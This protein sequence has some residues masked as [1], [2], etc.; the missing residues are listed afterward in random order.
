MVLVEQ[1]A[2][3]LQVAAVLAAI[4]VV[5]LDKVLV[6][7]HRQRPNYPLLPE[8]LIQSPLVLGVLD[9]QET[10]WLVQTA[11]TLFLAALLLLVVALVMVVPMILQNP[12]YLVGAVAVA[13]TLEITAVSEAQALLIKVM[14]VVMHPILLVIHMVLL[15]AAAPAL[16]GA[17][18]LLIFRLMVEPAFLPISL[19]PP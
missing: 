8:P 19:V 13:D 14:R 18:H 2:G 7:A 9:S 6:A 1:Q 17:P 4:V 11:L 10:T 3:G 12:V 16:L 15:A 5:W